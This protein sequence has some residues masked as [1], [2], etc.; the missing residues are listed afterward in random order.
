MK[1]KTSLTLGLLFV[2]LSTYSIVRAE[3][4]REEHRSAP[5]R[6]AAPRAAPPR[7]QAHPPGVHPHG[8]IVR[9]HPVR[10]M[11]SRVVVH[12]TRRWNHWEHVEFARPV[13]YWDWATIQNITCVAEDSYGD[14]YPV[15]EA[16]V[17]GFGL[18]NMTTVEDDTLDRCYAESGQDSSCFLATCSHF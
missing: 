11:A 18:D 4:R 10:V 16:T 5:V 2:S 9:Q 3:E 1:L 6:A 14:Q 7:F 12:G 17:P 15:T 8:P 13:Y